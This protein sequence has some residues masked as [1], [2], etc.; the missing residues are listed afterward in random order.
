MGSAGAASSAGAESS[1]TAAGDGS[2][3]LGLVRRLLLLAGT[4]VAVLAAAVAAAAVL[5]RRALAARRGRILAARKQATAAQL[6][7]DA[8]A[9]LRY[10]GVPVSD[11]AGS[12]E[13][14]G[15]FAHASGVDESE[16]AH[17]AHEA[18]R[19]AFGPD[20]VRACPADEH[21]RAA[22]RAA[23]EHAR[24]RLTGIRAWAFA[25]IHAWL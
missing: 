10:A 4:C 18:L 9:A 6:L 19:S 25:N 5:A 14:A 15:T 22:Y 12:A 11:D 8:C 20:G 23:C 24:A 13:F 2:Q 16:A 3:A 21:C 1:G 7:A 17:L